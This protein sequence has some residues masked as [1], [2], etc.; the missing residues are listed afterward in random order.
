MEAISSC[1]RTLWLELKS[2]T[3]ELYP[4]RICRSRT[5]SV[6]SGASQGLRREEISVRIMEGL[7]GDSEKAPREALVFW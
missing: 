6:G 3:V 1:D 7:R 5:N 2:S 4:A